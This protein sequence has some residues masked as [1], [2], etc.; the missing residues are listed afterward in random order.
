MQYAVIFGA[1]V[2]PGGLASGSLERRVRGALDWWADHPNLR[3][4][5]TGGIGAYGPAEAWV[6]QRLLVE[7]GVDLAHIILEDQA[8]DTLES[9]RYC[10]AL[11]RAQ[12]DCGEIICCTS[13]YHQLRCRLLF[14]MQG[15]TVVGPPMPTDR[16]PVSWRKLCLYYIKELAATPWDLALLAIFIWLRPGAAS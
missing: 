2:R 14:R 9:V 8:R 15:Y 12:G 5:P 7:A 1:A 3:F 4:M 10:D 13:Y 16:G 11:L 6:M